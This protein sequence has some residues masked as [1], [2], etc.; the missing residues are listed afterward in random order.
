[1]VISRLKLHFLRKILRGAP[2]ELN[3]KLI[4]KWNYRLNAL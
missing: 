4:K 1:M 2:F 3:Y